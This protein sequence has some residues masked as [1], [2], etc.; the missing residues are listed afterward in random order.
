[1]RVSEVLPTPGTIGEFDRKQVWLPSLT[2]G[3]AEFGKEPA[4]LVR[5]RSSEAQDFDGL[6]SPAA[7]GITRMAFDLGRGML[8]F[9]R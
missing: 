3:E 7:L 8:T 4:Y 5:S 1:M 9:S 2:V 6:M